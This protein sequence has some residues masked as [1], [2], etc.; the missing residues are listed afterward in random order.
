MSE[1]MKRR[2]FIKYA[3]TISPLALLGGLKKDKPDIRNGHL[4]YRVVYF[5]E[6]KKFNAQATFR[7]PSSKPMYFEETGIRLNA[8][9]DIDVRGFQER[10]KGRLCEKG[11]FDYEEAKAIYTEYV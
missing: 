3:T 9:G 5:E 8:D 10:V 6:M 7:S 2:K 11:I 4:S 1:K